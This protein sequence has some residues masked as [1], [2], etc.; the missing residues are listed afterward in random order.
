M[1][2]KSQRTCKHE[3][4]PK[5]FVSSELHFIDRVER[6]LLHIGP[7]LTVRKRLDALISVKLLSQTICSNLMMKGNG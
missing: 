3:G 1:T 7:S 4:V 5:C 6:K 2:E